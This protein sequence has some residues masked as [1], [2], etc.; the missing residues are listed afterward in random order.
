MASQIIEKTELKYLTQMILLLIGYTL[1]ST[2]LENLISSIFISDVGRTFFGCIFF[3]II[4]VAFKW[5]G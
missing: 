4:V 2:P 5:R 3:I 1:V